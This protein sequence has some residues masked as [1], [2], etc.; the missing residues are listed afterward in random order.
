MVLYWPSDT[1]EP[2]SPL[3]PGPVAEARRELEAPC[4]AADDDD[5]MPI[6]HE[7]LR[8]DAAGALI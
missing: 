1:S 6:A 8:L 7:S 2:N 3:A 4:P 5:L